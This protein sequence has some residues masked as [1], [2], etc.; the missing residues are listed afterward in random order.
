[1]KKILAATAGA[2]VLVVAGCSSATSSPSSA[3][4]D[5]NA[6]FRYVTSAGATSFDPHKTKSS[7]D[8]IVLNYVYDRLVQRDVNGAPVPGLAESWVVDPNL[9][10]ITFTLRSG[11]TFADGA[12][13]DADAVVANLNRAKE[14]DSI[15][16]SMLA[17]LAE[18]KAIDANTVELVLAK[19]DA[20]VLLTLTDLAG[21]IVNPTAFGT[22]EKNA[23]L[24]QMPAGSGRF[25]LTEST[26][27][28]H[29]LFSSRPN[30]WDPEAVKVK[31]IDFSVIADPQA[32]ING[33]SSG[34][35][36]CSIAEPAVVA[37]TR[38][39]PDL[40]VN[41]R[42]SATTNVLYFN[43]TKSEFG[44]EKVRQA[45]ALAVDRDAIVAGAME[46]EGTAT[47]QLF[48]EG[49]F[50]S[51]PDSKV[52]ARDVAKAKQLLAEAGLPNGFDFTAVTLAF[53]PF[54]TVAEI[55]QQQL[56]EIGVDMKIAPMPPAEMGAA[57]A[58]GQGDAVVTAW[59]GRA[60]P[61][62][63][64]VAYFGEGSPQNPSGT[65][66]DGFTEA[67]AAANGIGDHDARGQAIAKVGEGV[68]TAGASVPLAFNVV[69][70]VCSP[71]VVGYQPSVLQDEFRGI[72]V[73]AS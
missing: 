31:A 69:G 7:S 57:F 9:Q 8:G 4:A 32:R 43:R 22:P 62:T 54:T 20:S 30:Y 45:I 53:P 25:V 44:N 6:T 1:M 12:P 47:N 42:T 66:I 10:S 28:S 67:L 72:G 65:S 59:L 27:G 15:T 39:M 14:P 50:A 58:K 49:Y 23:A 29:Y 11:A 71:N 41:A 63:L 5:P 26:P 16:A 33:V 40:V 48:P 17:S 64:L 21:M 2:L 61:S 37:Q 36:D 73:A 24:A 35:F 56:K 3:A 13:I 34:Q 51:D 60:D 55:V 38:Q 19:P 70:A 68:V 18:A 52:P 46:G